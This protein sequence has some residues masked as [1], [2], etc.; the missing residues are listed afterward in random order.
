M[1][2]AVQPDRSEIDTDDI[3][4]PVASICP[5]E[6]GNSRLCDGYETTDELITVKI[7][8]EKVETPR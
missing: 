4:V 2:Q 6:T 1:I 8:M 7:E 3:I 5:D